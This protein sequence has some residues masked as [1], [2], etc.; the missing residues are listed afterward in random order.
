MKRKIRYMTAAIFGKVQHMS[1]FNKLSG[2]KTAKEEKHRE[3]VY[4]YVKKLFPDEYYQLEF[5]GV[6]P[7]ETTP[8]QPF[9]APQFSYVHQ[10]SGS[11]FGVVCRYF[12]ELPAGME[13]IG[14]IDPIMLDQMQQYHAR[15]TP[16]YLIV[17]TGHNLKDPDHLCLIP[18]FHLKAQ[19]N[20]GEILKYERNKKA[21]F[22]CFMGKLT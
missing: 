4:A 19:M 16:V 14:M 9:T 21:I 6:N 17:V 10:V 13:M 11:R 15:N 1:F 7:I 18:L 3:A 8:G 5:Q 20:R 12:P 22:G 2:R